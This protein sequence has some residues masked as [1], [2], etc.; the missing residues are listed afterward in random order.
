MKKIILISNT[1]FN[2]INYRKEFSKEL[3]DLG[4]DVVALL[5]E[6]DVELQKV[7][8]IGLKVETFK[9]SRKGINPLSEINSLFSLWRKIKLLSPDYVISYTVKAVI[10]GSIASKLSGVNQIFSNI[11]GLGYLFTGT[12]TRSKFLRTFV[13][14]P[15]YKLALSFNKIVFFQNNDDLNLFNKLK[16]IEF[17]RCRQINGSGVNLNYFRREKDYPPVTN[18][19]FKFL[20]VGR[21]LVDKG[22]N[23]L[24]ISVR[25]LKKK[26]PQISLTIIGD[27]DDNPAAL[28]LEEIQ[29]W[30]DDGIVFHEGRKENV[31]PYYD[32]AHVY[33]LPSYREGTPRATLEA[34]A[35]ALPIVTTSAPGCIETIENGKNG[36]MVPPRNQEALE[37]ALEQMILNPEYLKKYGEESLKIVKRKFDVDKVNKNIIEGLLL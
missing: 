22:V 30:I 17:R 9:L 2:I 10:Y 12:D 37:K 6:D 25:N 28:K 4:F 32:N 23:E 3:K 21:L 34:M 1:A 11:T 7:E 13:G 33:V 29:S 15:L 8:A 5:P 26:Y 24:L 27:I 20:Y 19:E 16:I 18:G 14:I 35:H 31:K 36:L